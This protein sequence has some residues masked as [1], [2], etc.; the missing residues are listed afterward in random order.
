MNMKTKV[1]AG[2]VSVAVVG[3]VLPL[4]VSAQ[5]GHPMVRIVVENNTMTDNA[6]WTGTLLDEWVEYQSDDTAV[7]L[8]SDLMAE[9]GYTQTG[10][11]VGYV[12]EIGGLK[13]EGMGGWMF[14]YDDWYGNSGITAFRVSDGTLEDGDELVFSYSMNWGADIGADFNS[15]STKLSSLVCDCAQPEK[16]DETTFSLTLPEGTEHIRLTPTAENKNYRFKI[17]QNEYTPEQDN[18]CKPSREIA[19]TDGDKIFIGVGHDTWHSW[20]PEGV[21]ETVY[22]VNIQIPAAE[23]ESSAEPVPPVSS[24]EPSQTSDVQSSTE[25]SSHTDTALSVESILKEVTE[26]VKQ[27]DFSSFG[28]EW[29]VLT[30]ARLGQ[31]NE[32]EK[33]AYLDSLK[34]ALKENPPA[35]ATDHAKYVLVLTS[36]GISAE[37]YN[38]IDFMGALNDRELSTVQ[39]INGV[40]YTLLAADAKPYDKAENRDWLIEQI[41][42]AQLNDGGWTFYGDV[43]DP[44]MTAMALQALAPYYAG[45]EKVK[46]AADRAVALLSSVQCDNGA[47]SSYGSV[48]CESTAQVVTALSA[49]GIDADHDKRFEKNGRSVLD[50]LKGF[51]RSGEGMF[52]HTEGDDANVYATWQ[53]YY[54][55]CAYQR[56]ASGQTR[57]FDMSDAFKSQTDSSKGES[58]VASGKNESS[59]RS[60]SPAA[61][62]AGTQ[63]AAAAVTDT[64]AVQTSDAGSAA[65]SLTVLLV[66]SAGLLFALIRKQNT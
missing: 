26:R 37:S 16:Q 45:N 66:L 21:Q 7:S 27:S 63:A 41:L 39:G 58:S 23:N 48:N 31:L 8:F 32:T 55:L 49:L 4:G 30:L 18:D 19:V 13:A 12:T 53:A 22:T 36:L 24:T 65:A 5:S 56:Y 34:T 61:P 59:T 33:A 2:I 25:E 43:Y 1:M 42:A 35:S 54:T 6:P 3:S 51:Y 28:H 57:L 38:G 44:D 10:A 15:T 64:G 17:Y 9:K 11:D 47:Y 40:V 60:S 62:A 14:G 29:E 46:E 52:A 50:A 20:M